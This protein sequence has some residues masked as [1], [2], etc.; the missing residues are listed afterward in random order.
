MS[1]PF[2]VPWSV[3]LDSNGTG[4]YIQQFA[5]DYWYAA[6]V[7]GETNGAPDWTLRRNNVFLQPAVGSDVAMSAG[8]MAPGTKLAIVITGGVPNANAA[9][10]IYGAKSSDPTELSVPIALPSSPGV[11][12]VPQRFMLLTS[13]TDPSPIYT[14]PGDGLLHTFTF[15]IPPGALT[16]RMFGRLFSTIPAPVFNVFQILGNNSLNGGINYIYSDYSNQAG[17]T[18]ATV[19]VNPNFRLWPFDTKLVVILNVTSNLTNAF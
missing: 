12:N 10:L 7:S 14:I 13:Q 15:P 2:E 5:N 19:V 9:G 3:V 8:V 6:T 18:T 4:T 17:S 1:T 16:I 11:L